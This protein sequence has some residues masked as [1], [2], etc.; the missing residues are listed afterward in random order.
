[1][2]K[3]SA[4]I[5]GILALI[6]GV[7]LLLYAFMPGQKV[8]TVPLWKWFLAFGL[9][10]WLINKIFF[11]SLL[12]NRLSVFLPLGLAFMLF[13]KE[14]GEALGKGKDFV[15][16]WYILLAVLLLDM[17]VWIMF[18]PSLKKMFSE[19][20]AQ[21]GGGTLFKMGEHVYYIDASTK[22]VASVKN[23]L[24]ELNVYFQNTDT[25]DTTTAF[26]LNV[27][28]RMGETVV[29]IPRDWHAAL[30]T[31]GSMGDISCRPDC[32]PVTRTININVN[33]Q[34]GTVKIVSDD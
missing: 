28:N 33:N 8:F 6:A 18:R 26:T 5:F 15:N 25:G 20:K 4:I 23:R 7:G 16:N 21:K 11:S 19:K 31:S 29:H 9:L 34:M 13:E 2:K 17:A 32:D 1:M 14:I 10:H 3:K 30:T 24:G 22:T 27:D 12:A